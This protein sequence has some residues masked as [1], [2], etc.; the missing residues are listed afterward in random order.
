MGRR[1]GSKN[2]FKN[3]EP[4]TEPTI[5]KRG[6]GRPKKIKINND[7]LEIKNVLIG[8]KKEIKS[9]IRQLKK[10][11]LQCKPGSK[12]RITLHRQIKDLKKGLIQQSISEPGKDK[13][14]DE[15]LKVDI[16]LGKLE[17]DLTKFSIAE[18][19]KHLDLLNKRSI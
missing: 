15:I 19:Q 3:I 17:I 13:L 7:E 16:L 9:E 18:L 10:L 8:D 5:I 6:R 2:K 4:T 12:E 14:I 1:K 11:K